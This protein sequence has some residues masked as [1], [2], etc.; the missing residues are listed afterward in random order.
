MMID[1]KAYSCALNRFIAEMERMSVANGMSEGDAVRE[2][3]G[4]LGVTRI[5]SS[6]HSMAECNEPSPIKVIFSVGEKCGEH[7]SFTHNTNDGRYVVLPVPFIR[8]THQKFAKLYNG[9]VF[10]FFQNFSDGLLR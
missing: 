1:E 10:V 3:C 9:K 7:I 5:E 2:L 6:V 4:I 8:K